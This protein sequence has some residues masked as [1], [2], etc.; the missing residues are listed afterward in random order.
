MIRRFDLRDARATRGFVILKLVFVLGLM[1]C[2]VALVVDFGVLIRCQ[3][4]LKTA[5]D[6]AGA[7]AGVAAFVDG[8]GRGLSW[9]AAMRWGALAAAF[10]V[11]GPATSSSCQLLVQY[12]AD[13]FAFMPIP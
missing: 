8:N 9:A 7:L 6:S 12:E 13:R 11:T 5:A 3:Q 1:I 10:D 2:A 4:Q